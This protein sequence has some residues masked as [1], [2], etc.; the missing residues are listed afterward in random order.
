M[1]KIESHYPHERKENSQDLFERGIRSAL[2]TYKVPEQAFEHD[3]NLSIRS[4]VQ[5]L[6]QYQIVPEFTDDPEKL[7]FAVA[8]GD[9]LLH[10]IDP[11]RIQS[12]HAVLKAV[13]VGKN[14]EKKYTTQSGLV[15]TLA[16]LGDKNALW[17]HPEFAD[18]LTWKDTELSVEDFITEYGSDYLTDEARKKIKS[19]KKSSVLHTVRTNL[20]ITKRTEHEVHVAVVNLD[21]WQVNEKM[22]G[23][24]FYAPWMKTIV[25]PKDLYGFDHEYAHSQG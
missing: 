16:T 5:L 4:T 20:G 22:I 7:L 3:P 8:V 14:G 9:S 1:V 23:G 2:N 25:L 11:E 17:Y 18:E 19:W 24:A 21:Q 10:Q 13:A 6:H 15:N 12:R